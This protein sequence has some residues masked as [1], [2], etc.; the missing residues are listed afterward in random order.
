MSFICVKIDENHSSAERMH[1]FLYLKESTTRIKGKN[2][3]N[4]KKI[5]KNKNKDEMVK[6]I[7]TIW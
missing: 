3:K 5:K 4:N 6:S 2:L 1:R 7:F